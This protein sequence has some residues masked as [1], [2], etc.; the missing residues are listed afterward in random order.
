VGLI[1]DT[2]VL[3]RAERDG[4][5]LDFS[6]WS[7]RG[8]A[9]ISAVT[10]SELL[11][12]VHRAEPDARRVRRSAW[13]EAVLA[14]IP[15]LPFTAEVARTHAAVVAV[16]AREGRLIGSHDLIIATTAL[17]HGHAVLTANS[18]EF[19]RVPGLEVL[20]PDDA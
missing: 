12:G 7:D 5:K 15:A 20:S 1:V 3:I 9:F 4:G 10:V 11:V 13:V 2:S 16:L 6:R 18:D 8:D 14:R 17:A 19:G